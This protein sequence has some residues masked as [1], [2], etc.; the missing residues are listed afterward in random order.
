MENVDKPLI[1]WYNN[2]RGKEITHF[3]RKADKIYA[4][5]F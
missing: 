2:I 3:H 4:R 1:E 5:N